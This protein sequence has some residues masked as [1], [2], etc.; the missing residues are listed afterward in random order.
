VRREALTLFNGYAPMAFAYLWGRDRLDLRFPEVLPSMVEHF[1]DE[2]AHQFLAD[3]RS[4]VILRDFESQMRERESR[5]LLLCLRREE[6]AQHADTPAAERLPTGARL[7]VFVCNPSAER[8]GVHLP[9]AIDDALAVNRAVDACIF[10]AG[11]RTAVEADRDASFERLTEAFAP[12]DALCPW[13]G[14]F[15]AGHADG[16]SGLQ[17][18]TADGRRE[19][20]MASTD[21]LVRVLSV[22]PPLELIFLNACHSA[23]IAAR[24]KAET[25]ARCVVCWTTEVVDAAAYLFARA[26]FQEC[27]S[28]QRA[29]TGAIDWQQAFD[30][31]ES[32]MT[33]ATRRV[34]VNAHSEPVV[35]PYFAIADPSDRTMLD[36]GRWAAGVPHLL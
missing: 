5:Q 13:W 26:F 7:L 28:Q 14:F 23:G 10:G 17:F 8:R 20:P 4:Q 31:G 2:A 35:R 27:A 18:T 3:L 29:D 6:A 21:E 34:R 33:S 16:A 30:A 12:S 22:E 9:N 1:G 25:R 36:D 11:S 19:E 32:A 24:L 15:F